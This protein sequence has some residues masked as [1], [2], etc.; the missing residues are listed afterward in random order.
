MPLGYL[1]PRL[2]YLELPGVIPGCNS[3]AGLRR[4]LGL[5]VPDADE[6][7]LGD[8]AAAVEIDVGALVR[9]P[10]PTQREAQGLARVRQ[11]LHVEAAI[12]LDLVAKFHPFLRVQ[13]LA[14]SDN[15]GVKLGVRLGRVGLVR[16]ELAGAEQPAVEFCAGAL[17][18]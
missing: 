5:V 2:V 12:A 15:H 16:A 13:L 9:Q 18:A 3:L 8:L 17:G 14:L 6:V 7:L 11:P 4:P 1:L 10:G